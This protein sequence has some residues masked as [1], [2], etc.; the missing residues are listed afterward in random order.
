[1]TKKRLTAGELSQKAAA[2]TTKYKS[3]EVGYGLT[4]TVGQNL[5]QCAKNHFHIIDEPEFCVVMILA[6]DPLIHNALRIKYYA[7]PFL[8]K[9]RPNQSCFLYTKATN[10]FKRLWVLPCAETMACLSS[11]V[12][13]DKAYKT[14]KGWSDAFFDGKFFQH[15]RNQHGINLL[16]EGEYLELHRE[17]L[18]KAGCKQAETLPAEPFD[19]SKVMPKKAVDTIVA[20]T[21]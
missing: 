16:S 19:F 1:M 18:I 21:E 2:D 3:M 13:V 9:P 4:E 7:W 20:P 11:M 14:M 8:P 12:A 10:K 15:I 5:E 17:E 6:S